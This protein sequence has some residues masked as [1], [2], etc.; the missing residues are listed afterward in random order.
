MSFTSKLKF[1]NNII[2]YKGFQDNRSC[3]FYIKSNKVKYQLLRN[4]KQGEVIIP[5]EFGEILELGFGEPSEEVKQKM[6]ADYNF[7]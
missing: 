2:L 3:F 7:S 1:S 6:K 5:S 4:K